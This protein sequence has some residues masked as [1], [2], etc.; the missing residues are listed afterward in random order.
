MAHTP[1]APAQQQRTPSRHTPRAAPTAG[2]WRGVACSRRAAA[3]QQTNT[4]THTHLSA[5]PRRVS[6]PAS[7]VTQL[8]ASAPRQLQL[9]TAA[10][11]VRQIMSCARLA[12]AASSSPAHAVTPIYIRVQ[13]RCS[14]AVTPNQLLLSL[15]RVLLVQ[16]LQVS[17]D[18]TATGKQPPLQ[19]AMDGA[20][21][22]WMMIT[23]PA[24]HA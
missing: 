12:D 13:K 5:A 15:W 11:G 14:A 20:E 3:H 6:P 17:N 2:V 19:H 1:G 24:H 7:C 4:H 8:A 9:E 23:T 18:Q 21:V 16:N 22:H 10:S